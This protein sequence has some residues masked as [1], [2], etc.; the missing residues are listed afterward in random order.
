[1]YALRM[2][3]GSHIRADS[4]SNLSPAPQM[5]V[6]YYWKKVQLFRKGDDPKANQQYFDKTIFL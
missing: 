1:M 5:I 2:E 6:F 4:T 3:H